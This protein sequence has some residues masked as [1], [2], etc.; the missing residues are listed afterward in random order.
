[1]AEKSVS[2][3]GRAPVCSNKGIMMYAAEATDLSTS[4]LSGIA[5]GG[6]ARG[7]GAAAAADDAVRVSR[8][9]T[10][11][12]AHL[13]ANP[14]T[15]CTAEELARIAGVT[16]PTLQRNVK[17]CLGISLARFVERERLTWLRERL[18]SPLES[19]SIALLAEASGYRRP[20]TLARSYQRLFGETPTE[21]RARA[22]AA[23]RR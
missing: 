3:S 21:T 22:F 5:P 11:A 2:Q 10:R 9:L 16:L 6:A 19:R 20:S 8:S 23:S 4:R 12:A 15:P 14:D 18:M 7:L 1:M 13:V 17:R